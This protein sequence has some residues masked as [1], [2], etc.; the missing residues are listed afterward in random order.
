MFAVAAP[1][2]TSTVWEVSGFSDFLKGRLANLSLTAD[3]IL[4]PGPPIRWTTPLDQPALW[5]I[6]AAP[7]GHI[8][9]ATGHSGKIYRVDAK[10]GSATPIWTAPQSEVFA[11]A[12]DARGVVYAGSSPN[13]SVYRIEGKNAS[14]LWRAPAKYIWSIQMGRDG[15]LYIATGEPGRVYRLGANATNAELLFDSGQPNITALALEPNGHVLAGADPNGL[16]YDISAPGKASVLYDSPLP[17]VRAIV[18]DSKGFIY[19]AAMGGALSTRTNS[20]TTSTA[21]ASPAVATSPTVIT[22]SE[23]NEQS[24]ARVSAPPAS[25]GQ[26]SGA[27]TSAGVS[28]VSGAEKSAIYRIAPNGSVE[29]IYSSKEGNVY[30]LLVDGDDLLFSTDA[31]GRIYR[32]HA[33]EITLVSEPGD[34][35]TTR[36]LKVNGELYSAMSNPARLLRF[37]AA[38]SA[39]ASYESEIHDATSVARWGHL[40][41]HGIGSG[42]QFRTRTGNTGR[43]DQT[44]SAWSDPIRDSAQALI[45]SPAA[46]FVQ[47]RAEWPAANAAALS[48][49]DIPYLPRNGAP[50]VHSISVVSVLGNT[51]QKS[52]NTAASSTAAYSVTVTD[53]G[54][55]PAASSAS[56]ATQSSARL[57]TPQTQISWQAD[58][59]DGDRLMYTVDFRA[60]DEKSWHLLRD[61]LFDNSLLLD[62]D[63]LADGRYFF[64]VVASDAP[65]N[66]PEFAMTS[67]LISSPILID[68][69]PPNVTFGKI[70]RN[71]NALDA[72]IEAE[73]KT[74]PLR[75]CEF[76]LDANFWQPV[77][78]VDGV[79]DSPKQ[80][81][82][83]HLENLKDGDHMLVV[84]VFDA[85]NNAG[86]ARVFLTAKMP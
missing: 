84:R 34:G 67:A 4:Q 76:S 36:L 71:G 32:W 47:W 60:E 9:A 16:T 74:S 63:A 18:T 54:E 59:P 24:G 65:A 29:T 86:L 35:E 61:H 80:K 14:E 30:D 6:A 15:D 68:N 51:P 55:A 52:G 10:D 41:W 64:R 45:S 33:H 3:G 26:G 48:T 25:M 50:A 13:G 12:T 69:T 49:V 75:L 42:V 77:E 5:A 70:T 81:F 8:F 17:E 2:A 66:A 72:E 37:T 82:H 28:E 7:D 43:P 38:A 78:A 58:D 40:Q 1:A 85:S 73:D 19:V 57:Q 56:S 79:T 31:N 11:L 53:T 39:T 44:W 46:R 83:L 22:V 27:T 23:A 20:T 62:A 21:V